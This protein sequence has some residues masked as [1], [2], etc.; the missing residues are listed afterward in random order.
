MGGAARGKKKIRL[1]YDPILQTFVATGF[2]SVFSTNCVQSSRLALPMYVSLSC[3]ISLRAHSL[4]AG[5]LSL[6]CLC[7][8]KKEKKKRKK[9]ERGNAA[10]VSSD[11]HSRTHGAAKET[12]DSGSCF[13]QGVKR[14]QDKKE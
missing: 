4:A 5:C 1:L 10:S 13:L 12:Q 6:I 7:E 8:M 11:Q 14:K 2:P 3:V 9:R